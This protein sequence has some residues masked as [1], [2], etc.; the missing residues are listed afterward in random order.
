MSIFEEEDFTPITDAA[1][2]ENG[3]YQ[4]RIAIEGLR[5]VRLLLQKNCDYG[6]SVWDSPLLCPTLSPGTAI[7]VRMSDKVKRIEQLSKS[8]AQVTSESLED[9]IRDLAGYCLL[10]LARPIKD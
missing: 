4:E 9:S 6:S 7:L 5:M 3:A 8:P 10:F 1:M 2:G